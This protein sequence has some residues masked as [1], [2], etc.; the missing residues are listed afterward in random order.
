MNKVKRTM[1]LGGSLAVLASIG[2]LMDRDSK[3][4]TLR[5]ADHTQAVTISPLPLPT[6]AAQDGV[7][8]VGITGSPTVQNRD[9]EKLARIPFQSYRAIN[10]PGA[11]CS[12][13]YLVSTSGLSAGRRLVIQHVSAIFNSV[14]GAATAPFMDLYD[15]NNTPKGHWYFVGRPGPT[16]GANPI[17]IDFTVNEDVLAYFDVGQAPGID[18]D[19]APGA[20]GNVTVTGYLENCSITG[21]P[22]IAP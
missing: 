15:Y 10:C 16:F 22:A 9:V 3:T 17:K 19:F 11:T 21:C 12:N 18:V 6:T 14:M 8:N 7:W 2:A 4:G 20:S 5:A 1:I 13:T